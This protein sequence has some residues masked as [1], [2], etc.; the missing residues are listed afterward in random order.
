MTKQGKQSLQ[1]YLE[2]IQQSISRIQRYLMH[3]D[4]AGFLANEEK[5]DAVIR[6]FVIIGEAAEKIRRN[7]PE[8]AEQHPE[9]PW[10]SVY[11]MRNAL[12]H[13]YFK[14]DLDV[15]WKTADRDLARLD[16][17]VTDLLTATMPKDGP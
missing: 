12:A 10:K 17:Q 11:G 14:V 9:F 1:G 3:V 4:H 16:I 8:F 15:V 6:N 13:G 5:Q 7:F 2:H